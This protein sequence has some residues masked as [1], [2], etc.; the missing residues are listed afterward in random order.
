MLLTIEIHI[1]V[2]K[3]MGGKISGKLGPHRTRGDRYACVDASTHI[4]TMIR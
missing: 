4:G 1:E 3:S 2:H